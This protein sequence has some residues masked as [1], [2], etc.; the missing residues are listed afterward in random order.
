V[1]GEPLVLAAVVGAGAGVVLTVLSIV[2]LVRLARQPELAR[3]PVAET[4]S[5]TFAEAGPVELALEGPHFTALF[6]GL[7]FAVADAGGRLVPLRK[8]L[9]RSTTSG[10]ARVRQALYRVDVPQPGAY[11]V[12]VTGMDPRRDYGDVAVVFIRPA[13]AGIALTI[14]S[15]L[16]SIGLTAAGLATVGALLFAGGTPAEVVEPPSPLTPRVTIPDAR[17][18]RALSS[19]SAR[20]HAPLDVTWPVL[21][22]R[23]QVPSDW[24][25]RK[26]STTE[27]DLRDPRTP[28]TAFLGHVTPMPAGP[29]FEAYLIEHVTHAREQLELRRIDGFA[30]RPIGNVPGVLTLEHRED[31]FHTITWTGF[32]PAAV[33]SLSITLVGAAAGDDFAREESLLGAIFES[34]SFD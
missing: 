22:M 25:V 2:R 11:T 24:V 34:I 28:S 8:L 6:R 29:T 13:G 15:L 19:D 30:T 3:A 23:V 21:R 16:A 27:I 14:V 20:L 26:L 12:R 10:F 17:G 4:S 31:G 5:V 1:T 32:Q 7:D 33:G 9:F 18:G